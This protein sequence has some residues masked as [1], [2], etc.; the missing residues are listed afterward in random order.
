MRRRRIEREGGGNRPP[1][2]MVRVRI[3]QSYPPRITAR[4]SGVG[5]SRTYGSKISWIPPR[6]LDSTSR[7]PRR[8]FSAAATEEHVRQQDAHPQGPGLASICGRRRWRI[9]THLTWDCWIPSGE[10]MPWLIALTRNT[11]PVQQNG[12]QRQH[13]V[14]LRGIAPA[15]NFGQD[16][17]RRTNTEGPPGWRGSYR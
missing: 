4:G 7:R 9:Y 12:R 6:K 11:S 16:F 17:N 1:F 2:R 5:S 10:K 3:R 14:R 15:P 13:I 8:L